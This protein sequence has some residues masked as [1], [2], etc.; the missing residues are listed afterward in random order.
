VKKAIFPTGAKYAEEI[1]ESS[2]TSISVMFCGSAAG[3]LAPPY[4]VY[5]NAHYHHCWGQNGPEGAGYH[6]TQSGW[7]DNFTFC[8]WLRKENMLLKY[9]KDS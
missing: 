1:R 7:F 9:K 4:V 5:K 8:E 3:V 2:K 6:A